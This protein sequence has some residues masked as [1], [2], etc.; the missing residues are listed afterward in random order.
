[1][2]LLVTGMGSLSLAYAFYATGVTDKQKL[3]LLTLAEQYNDELD[4]VV[5]SIPRLSRLDRKSVV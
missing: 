4:E 3:L 2:R 1:M 5:I